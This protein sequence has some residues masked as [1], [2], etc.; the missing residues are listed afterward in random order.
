MFNLFRRNKSIDKDLEAIE[1][2]LQEMDVHELM[3]GMM[4]ISKVEHID[5]SELKKHTFMLIVLT[6]NKMG[7]KIKEADLDMEKNR[8][9]TIA[10]D[11]CAWR[12]RN[13][14]ADKLIS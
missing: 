7:H 4:K 9:F 10:I 3:H 12:V 6:L 11:D 13:A 1:R 14:L 2:D 5:L 8:A